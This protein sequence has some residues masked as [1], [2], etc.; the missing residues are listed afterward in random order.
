MLEFIVAIVLII[1]LGLFMALSFPMK[2]DVARINE[3][4]QTQHSE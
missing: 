2:E 4:Q 1:F 3:P